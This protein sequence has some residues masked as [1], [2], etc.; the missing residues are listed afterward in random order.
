MPSSFYCP[1]CY[2]AW[3]H[4]PDFRKCVGCGRVLIPNYEHEPL[5][6]DLA[7]DVA[8]EIHVNRMMDEALVDEFRRDME[9]ALG[10]DAS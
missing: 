2:V 9:L 8:N 5:E 4:Q 10:P 3:P 6:T 1:K 7:K